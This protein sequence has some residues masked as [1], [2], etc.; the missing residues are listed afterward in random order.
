MSSFNRSEDGANAQSASVLFAPVVPGCVFA[1]QLPLLSQ[2]PLGVCPPRF[3][4]ESWIF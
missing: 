1:E 2:N 3:T 4:R